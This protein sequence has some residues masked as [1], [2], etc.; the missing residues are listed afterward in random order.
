MRVVL[1]FK[2]S[3]N[4]GGDMRNTRT[5]AESSLQRTTVR[6]KSTAEFPASIIN[7]R[8]R[9]TLQMS[10]A[11]K[12][13]PTLCPNKVPYKINY[14]PC[15]HSPITWPAVLLRTHTRVPLRRKKETNCFFLSALF[16]KM[17]QH[18]VL[19]IWNKVVNATYRWILIEHILYKLLDFT[20]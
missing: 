15:R 7:I 18:S 16:R 11:H 9:G 20:I 6:D 17:A 14:F 10:P 2:M 12:S 4:N 1:V 13:R 8:L 5:G 19:K 3:I